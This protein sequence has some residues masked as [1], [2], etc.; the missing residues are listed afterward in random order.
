[1][2]VYDYYRPILGDHPV[3]RTPAH[4]ECTDECKSTRVKWISDFATYAAKWT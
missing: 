1:M 3:P 2:T 4:I